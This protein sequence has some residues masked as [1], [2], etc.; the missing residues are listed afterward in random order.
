MPG[1]ATQK[2]NVRVGSRQWKIRSLSDKLQYADPTGDAKRAGICSASWSLFGQLWPAS[3]ALALAVKHIDIKNRRI[4]E[5]GCGLGLPSLVLQSRGADVT[6]SDRHPLSEPFLDYN[7]ALNNLPLLPYLDL[8]WEP[9]MINA[10]VGQFDLIIGSDILY[11]RDHADMLAALIDR[12]AAE[13]AKVLITCPGRGYR[14][15]FSRLLESSG[16]AL[17]ETTLPFTED[18]APPHRGRLL[19]YRR[20]M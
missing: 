11:E 6:A 17:T 12:L 19:C 9:S 10:D 4:I 5:L 18:E 8:A 3:Q 15:R 14:N 16:F 1:Y 20:G 7:A 2:L 13:K